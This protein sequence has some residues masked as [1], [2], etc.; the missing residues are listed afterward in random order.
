[1]FQALNDVGFTIPANGMTY[2]VGEAMGDTGCKDL[3][4]PFKE[5]VNA[6]QMMMRNVVHLAKL[7][8]AKNCPGKD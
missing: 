3:K 5:T 8:S 7:L 6:T 2:W 4:K 1:M